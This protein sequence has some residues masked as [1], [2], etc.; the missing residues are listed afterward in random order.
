MEN[1]LS[2]ATLRSVTC[3]LAL[4]FVSIQD[5]I[6]EYIYIASDKL[7]RPREVSLV[8]KV[9]TLDCIAVEWNGTSYKKREGL[10]GQV[11]PLVTLLALE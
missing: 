4:T 5:N 6:Q 1:S 10:A 9:K 8:Y 7:E 11:Q 2:R 3:H